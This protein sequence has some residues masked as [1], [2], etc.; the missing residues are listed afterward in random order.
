MR[1]PASGSLGKVGPVTSAESFTL[2]SPLAH[3]SLCHAWTRPLS[4]EPG[5]SLQPPCELAL[6]L[7]R[8]SPHWA[9]AGSP[10]G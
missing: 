9:S 3:S 7:L 10:M 4:L 1:N 8:P 2:F 6:P 5:L